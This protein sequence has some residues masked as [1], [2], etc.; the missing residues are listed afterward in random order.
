V[1]IIKVNITKICKNKSSR[2]FKKD[3]KQNKNHQVYIKIKLQ[4]KN[5]QNQ[6]RLIWIENLPSSLLR[7]SASAILF[8]CEGMGKEGMYRHVKA[9]M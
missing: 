6:I 3:H 1:N 2:F 9:G 5:V 4:L 8:F 7:I